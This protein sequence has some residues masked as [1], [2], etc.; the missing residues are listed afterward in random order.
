MRTILSRLT[1]QNPTEEDMI[2]NDSMIFCLILPFRGDGQKTPCFFMSAPKRRNH[3]R[4][5]CIELIILKFL[6]SGQI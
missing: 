2:G 1:I 6:K 3:Y 4:A 5:L